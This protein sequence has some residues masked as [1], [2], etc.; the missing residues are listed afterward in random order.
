MA[1][2]WIGRAW[3]SAVTRYYLTSLPVVLVATALGRFLNRR[4]DERRFLVYIHIGLVVIGG[5]ALIQSAWG[6]GRS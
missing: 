5:R 1:G 2:Y 4:M 3:V 6:A